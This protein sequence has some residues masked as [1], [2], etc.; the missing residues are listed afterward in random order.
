[1]PNETISSMPDSAELEV[2]VTYEKKVDE[3]G[4]SYAT[5]K[6]KDAVARVWVKP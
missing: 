1:M 5:G 4:R 6:R 2:P 3:K